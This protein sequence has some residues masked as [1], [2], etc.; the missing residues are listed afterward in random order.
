MRNVLASVAAAAL[1]TILL[2]PRSAARSLASPEYA[3]EIG[4]LSGIQDVEDLDHPDLARALAVVASVDGKPLPDLDRLTKALIH[5]FGAAK[6]FDGDYY[7]IW[8]VDPE[9]GIL[10]KIC[11]E[12]DRIVVDPDGGPDPIV[13]D[14]V[15]RVA[16]D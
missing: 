1:A 6:S 11:I 5:E 12:K 10:T 16:L 3:V 9:T 4:R 15:T 8:V 13:V 14:L 2:L 7:Y